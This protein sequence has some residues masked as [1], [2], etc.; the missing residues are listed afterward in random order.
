[1][2][3]IQP[4]LQPPETF[5]L[6]DDFTLWSVRMKAFLILVHPQYHGHY[7]LSYL[8]DPTARRVLYS[9][10]S[11]SAPPDTL[12]TNLSCL[13]DTR[14][15]SHVP[16]SS[17]N[18]NPLPNAMMFHP[19]PPARKFSPS[20][21]ISDRM[22]P[23]L[24]KVTTTKTV[25]QCNRTRGF[26]QATLSSTD[27]EVD[28]KEKQ[29]RETEGNA[30]T[31]T[32]SDHLKQG[33]EEAANY[34]TQV[35]FPRGG[36]LDQWNPAFHT[37]D[38][39]NSQ[40]VDSKPQQTKV[41][42]DANPSAQMNMGTTHTMNLDTMVNE[43]EASVVTSPAG[44]TEDAIY[45][46]DPVSITSPNSILV[47]TK[48]SVATAN[49]PGDRHPVVDQTR[50]KVANSGG[51]V[52]NVSR[53]RPPSKRAPQRAQKAGNNCSLSE[54][55]SSYTDQAPAASDRL[56]TPLSSTYVIYDPCQPHKDVQCL[57][58][59]HLTPILPSDP[60]PHVNVLLSSTC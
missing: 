12:W 17:S 38:D 39:D 29:L 26:T 20:I 5:H 54:G 60:G 24:G 32:L 28:N 27:N 56:W 15:P 21:P 51:N 7:I 37:G 2:S 53:R 13:F 46:T 55:F 23:Y 34:R 59:K 30:R 36:N 57:F 41:A 6:G 48:T 50:L 10:V 4:P 31:Q 8:D 40:T 43:A 58:Y 33:Y 22:C 1:M 3:H 14:P 9:G 49:T 44:H 45:Q 52:S 19:H 47:K 35:C 42:V 16:Q 25:S 18:V 11:L